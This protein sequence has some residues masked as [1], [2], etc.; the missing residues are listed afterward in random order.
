[1]E[2]GDFVAEGQLEIG[3][4]EQFFVFLD[5]EYLGRLLIDH[6]D[7][8]AKRGYCDLGRV[9][10]TVEKLDREQNNPPRR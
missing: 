7:M 6:F 10:I 4:E 5:G 2:R 8:P 9:R 3:P 1:M